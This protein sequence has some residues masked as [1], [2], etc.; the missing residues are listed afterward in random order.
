MTLDRAKLTAIGHA[1]HVIC[2]PIDMEKVDDVLD[3]LDLPAGAR[4]LDA[5]CGK[6]EILM[7]LIAR[8]CGNPER[9]DANELSHEAGVRCVGVDV[10]GLFLEEARRAAPKR[11]PAWS[12]ELIEGEVVAY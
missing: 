4:V 12:L 6:A 11:V 2:N 5:G 7:R 8:R 10:N 3:L 9:T 1:D